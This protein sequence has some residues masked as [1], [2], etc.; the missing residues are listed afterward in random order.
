MLAIDFRTHDICW[1]DAGHKRIECANL[2]GE[3]R[4]V[5]FTPAEYP[6]GLAI[7]GDYLF[8]SDWKANTVMK[9]HRNGGELEALTL[10][11]GGNGK[12]YDVVTIPK[13]CPQMSNACASENG[14]CRH[15]CLPNGKGG[16]TCACP[17]GTKDSRNNASLDINSQPISEDDFCTQ[18]S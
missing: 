2:N 13:D 5:V 12:V 15:L 14:G 8:W 3:N 11:P 10:P 17:D 9:V 16:R 18:F 4:R 1:T 6:F 7:A